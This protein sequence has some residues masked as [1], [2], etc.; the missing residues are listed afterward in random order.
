[1]KEGGIR[2]AAYKALVNRVPGI[3]SRYRQYRSRTHGIGRAGAWLYLLWLNSSYYV[4][5]NKALKTVEK[6]PY[7][8][9]K[10]LLSGGSESRLSKRETPEELAGKLLAYDVVSFDVFDTLLF[11]PFSEPADLFYFVADE[12]NYLDFR[13]IRC[14]MEY[15]SREALYKK[16][17]SREVNLREIYDMIE[18][19]TGIGADEGMSA[20]LAAEYRFCFANPYMRRVVEELRR[21]GKRI[22]VTSDMYLNKEQICRLLAKAGYGS[23]DAC[24]ISSDYR[25]SKSTG[26]LYGIVRE[27]E[28]REKRLAHVGDHPVSDIEQ[29]RKQGI[30]AFHYPNVNT[31]GLPYRA[32]DMSA[33]T[34]SLYRGLVNTHIHNGLKV[35]SQAYEYG[36]IYG[37]L[38]AVGYCR[39]IHEYAKENHVEKLLFLARDGEILRQVYERMYPGEDTEYVY[40]SRLAAAKLSAE[41]YK[42]DYFR[43]FLYHKVNQGYRLSDIFRTM[44]LEDMLVRM[45]AEA[46]LK[47]ELVLTDKNAE[48]VKGFLMANWPEVLAHY[49]EQ[50][51]AAAE[52]YRQVVKGIKKA[53]AVDIGWAGSG[54]A[55]LDYMINAVWKLDCAVTGIIAGTNSCNT[56]EMNAN[57]PQLASGKQ[58]SYLFSQQD[59]RDL[60]KLHDAAKNHNL[61]WELFLDS[62]DGSLKGFYPDKQGGYRIVLKEPQKNTDMIVQVR[63]G[64][65]DF[66]DRYIAAVGTGNVRI[67]G[68]DA[69]APMVLV[70]GRKNCGYRKGLDGKLDDANLC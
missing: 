35:Y 69:Y 44:E 28:G 25:T 70:E 34:G 45:C 63:N 14:E 10:K 38:F 9:E 22:V 8:E 46:G 40:W 53:A 39:F 17:G 5:R 21:H 11:R 1:M 65:L 52:Y 27:R 18:T 20:E 56:Y 50:V 23:F 3:Q 37:G 30:Y 36:F 4:L 47:A 6:Y 67:S 68:R 60:W 32:E 26:G 2:L 59:N 12:L 43:R 61:Y 58:V 48:L 16:S 24:Y 7:Y 31:I 33:V 64:I 57:A 51:K 15:K 41:R 13:R 54:A 29:A 49:K 62:P 19:E 66:A 55:T 42:Y